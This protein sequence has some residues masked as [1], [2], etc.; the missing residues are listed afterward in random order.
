MPSNSLI[1]TLR[2]GVTWSK[3]RNN[4]AQFGL[5]R[6]ATIAKLLRAAREDLLPPTFL[7][8]YLFF[9]MTLFFSLFLSL[10]LFSHF[11]II[12]LSSDLI[13]PSQEPSS[14]KMNMSGWKW[15]DPGIFIF[16]SFFAIQRS[17]NEWDKVK[18]IKPRKLGLRQKYIIFLYRIA[19]FLLKGLF[20]RKKI[21][22][23]KKNLKQKNNIFNKFYFQVLFLIL[24]LTKFLKMVRFW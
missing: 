13:P 4:S 14:A 6:L 16:G 9:Y 17:K 7:P 5:I 19:I 18:V 20:N 22:F 11:V 3:I 24:L 21:A 10:A 1:L 23:Y 2:L 12:M 15:M 8:V